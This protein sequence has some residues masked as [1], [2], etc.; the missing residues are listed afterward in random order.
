MT[1]W[2]WLLG[3]SPYHVLL[4]VFVCVF[5]WI[6]HADNIKRLF[7]GTEK[8]WKKKKGENK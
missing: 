2:I 8:S 1:T 5:I 7:A 4:A 3:G 6:K